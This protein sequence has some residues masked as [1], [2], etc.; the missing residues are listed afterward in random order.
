MSYPLSGPM[1]HQIGVVDSLWFS[2][3]RET[4]KYPKAAFLEI[5]IVCFLFPSTEVALVVGAF[6]STLLFGYLFRGTATARA[7]RPM[8]ERR[9]PPSSIEFAL[10]R[11]IHKIARHS[12]TQVV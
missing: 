12:V 2:V 8:L 11:Q 10:V 9:A 6:I 1:L 4:D 3:P 5:H 7:V